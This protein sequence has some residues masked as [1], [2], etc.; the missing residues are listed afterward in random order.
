MKL[1]L[2]LLLKAK[3][4]DPT[5]IMTQSGTDDLLHILKELLL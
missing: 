4:I 3:K 5:D 2:K 1:W